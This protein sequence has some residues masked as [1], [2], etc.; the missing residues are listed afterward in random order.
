MLITP[1]DGNTS[2]WR[3]CFISLK[4]VNPFCSTLVSQSVLTY[5]IIVDILLKLTV[6]V[7]VEIPGTGILQITPEFVSHELFIHY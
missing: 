1:P 7:L 5:C 2:P 3:G 4:F 6:F